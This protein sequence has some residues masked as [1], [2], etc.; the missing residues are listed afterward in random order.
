VDEGSIKALDGRYIWAAGRSTDS[1]SDT[2]TIKA[3][4][5]EVAVEPQ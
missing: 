5:I 2:P 3:D 1:T 4:G